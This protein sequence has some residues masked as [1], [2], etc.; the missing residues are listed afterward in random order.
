MV[1]GSIAPT[2][3]FLLRLPQFLIFVVVCTLLGIRDISLATSSTGH[4]RPPR[5]TEYPFQPHPPSDRQIRRPPFSPELMIV[6]HF[7]EHDAPPRKRDG[8]LVF[9]DYLLPNPLYHFSS[10]PFFS[11]RLPSP[12]LLNPPPLRGKSDLN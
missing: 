6:R 3:S 1:G 11:P 2:F 4:Q 8:I 5:T 10:V 12:P 7:P 9:I